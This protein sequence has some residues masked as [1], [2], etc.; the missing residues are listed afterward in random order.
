AISSPT[1]R[2]RS[3]GSGLVMV[4]I[5]SVPRVVMNS[6]ANRMGGRLTAVLLDPDDGF[7]QSGEHPLA[8]H[9]R[10]RQRDL[11]LDAAELHSEVMPRPPRLD[12]QI[13][14]S[15][16]QDVQGG[17]QLDLP[18][19]ADVASHQVI[20]QVEDRGGRTCMPKKQR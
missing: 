7:E 18:R 6:L 1:E 5:R 8:V 10:Q 11:G 17:R 20:E 13:F 4:S 2:S 3:L 14:F 15:P 9:A 16:R 12:R 19:L